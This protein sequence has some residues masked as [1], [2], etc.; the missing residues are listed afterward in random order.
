MAQGPQRFQA[1]AV[2]PF[3]IVPAKEG[4][5]LDPGSSRRTKLWNQKQVA[6]FDTWEAAAAYA[7]RHWR[8][9][10]RF[11]ILNGPALID[12]GIAVYGEKGSYTIEGAVHKR[13]ALNLGAET[14]RQISAGG[15]LRYDSTD[16]PLH[17]LIQ[18]QR[19]STLRWEI[20]KG[21]IKRH[22]SLRE[23][24]IREV[25]EE[26]GIE[27]GIEAGDLLGRV[28]YLF[29]GD[30]DYLFFKSVHYFLLF[31]DSQGA[32]TPREEEC[33]SDA[34]WFDAENAWEIVSFPNLRPIL[35]RAARVPTPS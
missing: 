15:V 31:A 35:Q 25:R 33:I 28:D 9:K 13:Y 23:A 4:A 18:V 1:G 24:A 32:L 6:A 12:D 16:G 20:P 10:T 34:R 17:A 7:R 8:R 2:P 11:T 30:H 29:Y 5:T 21:K 3:L 26:T 22:E 27:A 14:R 19:K